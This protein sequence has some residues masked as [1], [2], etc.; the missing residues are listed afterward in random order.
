MTTF[1]SEI[2]KKELE[3]LWMK[4]KKEGDFEARQKLI[5]FYSP[6]AK[7]VAGRIASSLPKAVD[8]EDLVQNGIIG[9]IDA[10]EKFN[11]ELNIKFETYAISRIRGAIIDSLRALDWL[12]RSLRFKAKELDKIY[13]ELEA[14][15]KRPPTE[16]ELAQALEVSPEQL[17]Q[18]MTELSYSSLVA[19][20][21]T[22]KTGAAADDESSLRDFISDE[23]AIDP[24]E[25]LESEEAKKMLIKAVQELP[26]K[27]RKVIILYYYSG[28]TL[29]EIGELLGVSESRASQIHSKAI[30]M[31]KSMLK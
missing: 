24:S 27:E 20:E 4:Y 28:L 18:L 23:N 16:E 21:E 7:Y 22:I 26:E 5:I 15:L 12:P 30:S 10:I 25:S 1:E 3:K 29:K 19:L 8:V 9:L 11:P 31:L 17:R 2:T 14:K 13:Q 6:L